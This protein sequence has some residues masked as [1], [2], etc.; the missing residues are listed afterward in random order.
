MSS[1]EPSLDIRA[2]RCVQSFSSMAGFRIWLVSIVGL[3]FVFALQSSYPDLIGPLSN[4]FPTVCA[5]GAFASA[6]ICLRRYGFGLRSFEAAWF[7]FT[8]G[9]GLWVLAEATWAL[10]YF[11]LNVPVPYPSLADFFY[12]GGYIPIIAGLGAY[13]GTFHMAMSRR[14]LG[15]ALGMIGVA[16]ALAMSFVLPIE[17]AQSLPWSRVI[18]D[19]LY[20]ILDLVLLSFAVISLAIFYGG[21]IAKWWMLFGVGAGLYVFADEFFLYQVANGTYYNGSID[22]FVFMFG[23]LTF[24][25]A[26]YTHRKE[27]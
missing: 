10:Y 15:I 22:D 12:V 16:A 2:E 13:L 9:T 17:F 27:L 24:A 7:F 11:V 19:L 1:E 25:L 18:T 3:T 26:F 5:G 14:R 20:P 4:L 23:Y 8:L 21:S 6:L